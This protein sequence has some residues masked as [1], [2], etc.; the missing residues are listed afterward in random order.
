MQFLSQ[1]QEARQPHASPPMLLDL[2]PEN[3]ENH[4]AEKLAKVETSP[5][6][7]SAK[8]LSS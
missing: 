2:I 3:S 7:S 1:T 6:S 8:D 5:L 4:R